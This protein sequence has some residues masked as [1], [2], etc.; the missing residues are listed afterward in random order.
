MLINENKL[1][2]G[3][4]QTVLWKL[5]TDSVRTMYRNSH[6]PTLLMLL[7]AIVSVW[8]IR[9]TAQ[10]ALLVAWVITAMALATLRLT[11]ASLF[12]RA[13]LAQQASSVWRYMLL[14]CASSSGFLLSFFAIIFIPA[15][16]F[17]LQLLLLGL[18]SLVAAS[19]SIG[20]AVSFL[21]FVCYAVFG[22]LPIVWVYLT[23][24]SEVLQGYGLLVLVWLAAVTVAVIQVNRLI[25]RASQQRIKNQHLI[26]TLQLAQQQTDALNAELTQEV[27][28]K[29]I[30]EQQLLVEQAGLE[31]RVNERTRELNVA[32][33]ALEKSQE[34]LEL[35][36]DASQLALWDWNLVTD[37]VLHTRT[38]SIFGLEDAQ[39]YDVLSD[40]RPLLHPDD[41]PVLR[42]AMIEHMKQ[43]TDGY[44]V[45]YRVKHADGHWVWIIDRGRAV[46]RDSDGRVL[47]MLGTRRDISSRKQQ[48]EEQRLA[49][50]VFDASTESI[51]ILDPH[52]IVLSVNKAYTAVTGF[53]RDDV[54]GRSIILETLPD[55]VRR[56]YGLI[57]ASIEQHGHWQG[58]S[59]DVRKN[60]EIYPQWLQIHL[61]RNKEGHP[62]HIVAFFTDLTTRRQEEE[63]L[64][65][66]T[67]YDGLT[68]LANRTLFHQ[69]L[70]Q[71]V[72]Q[73]R[74]TE[75]CIALMHI[76]LDRFKILND[77]LGVEVADQVLRKI[78]RRLAQLLPEA[79]TLAR[80]G[81][82]EF[83]IIL[84]DHLSMPSLARLAASVLSHIQL[85]MEVAGNELV[86]SASLGISVLPDSAREP[87]ALIS[88]AHIAMQHAKHLGGDNY[89]FYNDQLQVGTLERLQLEQQL[90]R[91]IEE[92]QLQAYYQPK[93]TLADGGIRSAE[94]L[95]RWNHPQRGLV[96][97]AEFIPLA[98]ETGLISAI[99]ELMLHQACEQALLWLQQGMPIRVSV[100][101]S[102][103]HVRQGNLV[104][105]VRSVLEKTG[106]PAYLLE[107]ELTESQM[108]E[109][110]ESIIVTFKQLRALGVHLAI[111]DFGTGYSSLSYL[112]RFPANCVKIDQSFIRDVAENV[113]D[114]AITRAIIAMAH[115]LNLLVIAEGVETQAQMDFLEANLCDEVQGYLICRPIPA[116]QFTAF[117]LAREHAQ[118]S[119]S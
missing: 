41:L 53:T 63:R 58:E 97:P 87:A 79:H 61:V 112:K 111:D 107:L 119:L 7:C 66:L 8:L 51:V 57:R 46:E 73:A 84:D 101:L 26:Q 88:Q 45:E 11:S 4:K 24:D 17:T 70:Q 94:A 15:E 75:R 117:L 22:F 43:R 85:P 49:A 10:F 60:G 71:V 16:T 104:A 28:A 116:E 103:S 5:D 2:S 69:R 21:L 109:N 30:A 86:V 20:Y 18:L 80:L 34:R 19:T 27:T 72:E 110:A 50:T 54:V 40:L 56:Q 32:L 96:S 113:E 114:A 100:N 37:E 55:K 47:R 42:H 83:A 98:E 62:T 44:A 99:S 12:E 81:G 82:N 68:E 52:Y 48:E 67:Q 118:L 38:K 106:L 77:S 3:E 95:V 74:E 9:D 102:V 14:A 76:D 115:G 64:N 39:I 89:Q 78:S 6:T 23:A 91:G 31:Q 33:Q 1:H 13:T 92:G 93:L 90:R 25:Y 59:F 35:A 65:Y 29:Q 105:L 108:L 36:L